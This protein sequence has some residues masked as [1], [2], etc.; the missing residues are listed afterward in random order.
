MRTEKIKPY[1]YDEE[2][3]LCI[4]ACCDAANS[5]WMQAGRLSEKAKQGDEVARKKLDELESTPML[6]TIEEEGDV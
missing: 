1:Y 3:T 5:D 4:N 6:R 2:G